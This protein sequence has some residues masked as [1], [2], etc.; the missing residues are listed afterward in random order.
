M[1]TALSST[2]STRVSEYGSVLRPLAAAIEYRRSEDEQVND[3]HHY[4]L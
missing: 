3:P 4:R 1:E 2:I